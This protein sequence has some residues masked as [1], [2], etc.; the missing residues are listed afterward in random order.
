MAAVAVSA[1]PS[2]A[3]PA[4][5]LPTAIVEG[6]DPQRMHLAEARYAFERRHLELALARAGGRR[7]QAA[8]E[9]GLSRQGLLKLMA[10]R[11]SNNERTRATVFRCGNLRCRATPTT[12]SHRR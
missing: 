8:R 2:G 11:G 6:P 7:T 5:L 12:L 4:S 9:L 1:P 3:V 10:R